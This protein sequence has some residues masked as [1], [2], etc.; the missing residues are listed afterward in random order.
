MMQTITDPEGGV[1]I[2]T[3][4]GQKKCRPENRVLL[5]RP[6]KQLVHRPE[7]IDRFR[8]P[9]LPLFCDRFLVILLGGE[10]EHL[11]AVLTRKRHLIP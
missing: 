4:I 11:F 5:P 10:I 2:R 3:G 1:L 9:F 8:Q 6:G 7:E